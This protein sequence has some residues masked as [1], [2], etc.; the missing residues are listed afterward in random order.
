MINTATVTHNEYFMQRRR[1][2]TEKFGYFYDKTGMPEYH[3]LQLMLDVA[4]D[5]EKLCPD[6]WV[7]LA[8]NPVF[9]G[10][11]LMTRE[12]GIKVCGLCHGHYGYAGVATHIGVGSG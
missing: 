9:A 6:A 7:L 8:G 1:K 2:M 12:T 11:T 5:M 10:T 4:R 3:N